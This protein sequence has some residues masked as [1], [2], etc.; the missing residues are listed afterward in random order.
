[1]GCEVFVEPR[2]TYRVQLTARFGFDDAAAIADYLADLGV[3]HLYC[4][5]YLQAAPAAR[6]ATTSS[7]TDSTS[8]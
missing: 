8:K 7:T 5:P 2:A 1:V 3:S 6:T 4:S